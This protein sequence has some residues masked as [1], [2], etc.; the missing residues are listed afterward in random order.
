MED[1]TKNLGVNVL[2]YAKLPKRL[3][4]HKKAVLYNN[5][6]ILVMEMDKDKIAMAPNRDTALMIFETYNNLGIATNKLT[7]FLKTNGYSAQAGHPLGGL[8]LYPPLAQIA[9]L[10]WHGRHGLLITPDFG[11]RVRLA[12]VY[13]NISNLP[14]AKENLHTWIEDFCTSC[15]RCIRECPAKAINVSPILHDN[16]LKTHIDKRKCFTYFGKEYGCSVCIK[17]CRFNIEDYAKLKKQHLKVK[18][19]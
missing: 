4:F 10:G 6:I 5:T 19:R 11:P 14:V 1:F 18:L 2:G 16:G 7:E 13:T 17:E 15:G 3:I 12:A 8:A 9:G